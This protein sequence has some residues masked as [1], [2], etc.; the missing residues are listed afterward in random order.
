MSQANVRPV[1]TLP[2]R[3]VAILL[4]LIVGVVCLTLA[5]VWYPRSR[6]FTMIGG[7]VGTSI[8]AEDAAR[9]FD[10]LENRFGHQFGPLAE[11]ARE[12]ATRDRMQKWY[13]CAL[14]VA[15]VGLT[16]SGIALAVLGRARARQGGATQHG[17][18]GVSNLA[19]A[20]KNPPSVPANDALRTH[21]S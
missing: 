15:G 8:S 21:P 9:L 16:L 6:A 2:S 4:S 19:A 10:N 1:P 7:G 5:V 20:E 11:Q 3:F 14:G 17:D 12:D 18:T 13:C